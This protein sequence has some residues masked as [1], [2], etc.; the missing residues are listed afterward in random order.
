MSGLRPLD[1]VV[2][3]L[4]KATGSAAV[5][6]SFFQRKLNHFCSGDH[7]QFILIVEDHA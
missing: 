2:P 5:L 7:K 3:I 4:G 1:L 6:T